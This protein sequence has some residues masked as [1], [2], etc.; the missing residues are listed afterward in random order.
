MNN[1]INY[2]HKQPG[3][4]QSIWAV[5][6]PGQIVRSAVYCD[7]VAGM[8]TPGVYFDRDKTPWGCKN[9]VFFWCARTPELPPE[10][11]KPTLTPD[12]F[13]Q[14]MMDCDNGESEQDHEDADDLMCE[15]LCSLGYGEGIEVF[16]RMNKYY[17]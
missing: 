7:N 1:W 9:E 15:L 6:G 16:E 8:E 12:K 5:G 13:L 3:N 4:M 17:S 2:Q 10:G 14:K 11:P